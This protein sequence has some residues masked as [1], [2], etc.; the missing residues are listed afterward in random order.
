MTH[1]IKI[2]ECPARLAFASAFTSS[3]LVARDLAQLVLYEDGRAVKDPV[4]SVDTAP[5]S[6]NRAGAGRTDDSRADHS[7][8]PA[9]Q[10]QPPARA[11]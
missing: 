11:A 10:P 8:E 5:A 7:I 9:S 1:S 3:V 6:V 4:A 2:V